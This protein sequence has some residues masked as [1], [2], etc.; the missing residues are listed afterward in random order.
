MLLN[1]KSIIWMCSTLVITYMLP[2]G[3]SY[4]LFHL[5]IFILVTMGIGRIFPRT[6]EI[7]L[8]LLPLPLSLLYCV[9]NFVS[10][11]SLLPY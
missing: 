10:V 8:L 5:L 2:K 6:Q 4:I 9:P 7:W 3:K 11:F 1:I